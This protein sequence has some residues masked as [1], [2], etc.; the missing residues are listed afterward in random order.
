M[1]PDTWTLTLARQSLVWP[2]TV[3]FFRHL[4]PSGISF[5][6][7]RLLPMNEGSQFTNSNQ[8]FHTMRCHICSSVLGKC[9][10]QHAV[11]GFPSIFIIKML[12]RVAWTYDRSVLTLLSV[13]FDWLHK[14]RQQKAQDN[15]STYQGHDWVADRRI[16]FR[17]FECCYSRFHE[18]RIKFI[19]ASQLSW[20]TANAHILTQVCCHSVR[21]DP[22]HRGWFRAWRI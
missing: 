13:V 22:H 19:H 8:A 3:I 10:K 14:T 6:I 9:L 11:W 5:Y 1:Y 16:R 12:L 7:W 18:E 17:D 4:F 2:I 15:L 21:M 20:A